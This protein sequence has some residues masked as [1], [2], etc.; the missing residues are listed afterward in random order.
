MAIKTQIV[1]VLRVPPSFRGLP[2][3][4]CHGNSFWQCFDEVVHTDYFPVAGKDKR[5]YTTTLAEKK[6][7]DL[8]RAL[9]V[10]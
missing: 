2:H 8:I 5:P 4:I 6:V 10:A 1:P 9:V 7:Q 3:P